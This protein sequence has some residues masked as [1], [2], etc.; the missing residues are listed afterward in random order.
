MTE[1]IAKAKIDNFINN[2]DL[3]IETK[4]G[5][6]GVN[7]SGGQRQRIAI[8]RSFYH[9]KEFIIFDEVTS[10]LDPKTTSQIIKE[11]SHLKEN[12]V[13]TI[14]HN[15]ETIKNCSRI[16]EIKNGNLEIIK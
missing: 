8:A 14:S 9:D 16:F 12:T 11:I 2:L 5:E 13:I 4:V 1:S 7:L 6:D 10:A 3:G 15:H